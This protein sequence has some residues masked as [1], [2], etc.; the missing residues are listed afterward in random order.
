MMKKARMIWW[1]F[2]C[3]VLLS[4]CRA[5]EPEPVNELEEGE[6]AVLNESAETILPQDS[7]G[8]YP[9]LFATQIPIRAD[10]ATIGSTFANHMPSMQQVGRGGDLWIRYP[11]G[12]LK[13]LTQLAGYGSTGEFQDDDAIAVRD[14][15]VHWD[16]NKAVFSMVIGAP[17][18]QYEWE[19][20]Y[21]QLYEVTG[22]GQ[23][24]TP[25][26]AK[27]PNQPSNYNNVSPVYASDDTIIFTSDRP[28]NG[29][30]H[31]YPQL[32]EYEE[33]PT[34]TGL[35]K[36]NPANGALQLLNHAPSGDFTP[37]VDSFGRVVF[38]QWD[39]LQRDQQADSDA[40]ADSSGDCY[41]GYYYGTFNY[42]NE[43]PDAVPLE[44]RTEIFPEPRS[45]R[46]DLLNG[47]NL[48]GHRF[49][50]FFPWQ[51]NEDGTESEVLNHLGRQEL[52]DY[53][54]NSIS[55]DPN[56]V[57]YYG[58]YP[59]FNPNSIENM[60][61][62]VEDPQQPGRYYGVEAPEFYTHASGQVIRIDAPPT[63]DA[64]HIA[65]THITHPDTA[66]TTDTPDHS[67][68][69]RDPLALSD[70]TLIAAHTFETGPEATSGPALYDFRLRTLTPAGNGYLEADVALTSGISKTVTYWD[71]DASVTY[72]GYLW[73]MY[74]EEVRPRSRPTTPP[75]V[76][77]GPE[78]Q[79]FDQAGVSLG[80]FQAYLE[81]NKLALVVSR[82]VTTR[83]DLDK[84]QP[85]NLNVPAGVQTTGAPGTIYDVVYIQF[86]QADLLRGI[87]W[88]GPG[89][90][91]SPG[92]RVLA[93]IL[94]DPAV[95]NPP[96]PGPQGSAVIAPDGSMAA[97]VPAQRA[98]SW[99]LTDGNGTGMVRERYWLTFQPGEV[100]VCTS[101][102][103][104]SEYDQAGQ[105]APS[106]PP[107]ALLD[108]LLYWQSLGAFDNE[109]YLPAALN[110]G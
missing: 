88:D 55:G 49:N 43:D 3:L 36:L 96:S 91:P 90:D 19:D 29:A 6:S 4:G 84:Q 38:T 65:V 74:P 51:I 81:Q 23:G 34:V 8:S 95:H 109:S 44:D 94:H 86:F 9:I 76:L 14:P 54:S 68:H 66:G 99:Q 2:F 45:C 78:Q 25:V 18:Q 97:F 48:V 53:I 40:H 63:T 42:S 21:W 10:F 89:D 33:T 47:T 70:G 5:S 31:L 41:G 27:V 60:F 102:H 26:I 104:L 61:Q 59:R 87:G 37:I 16:G 106:N 73:E 15:A 7:G 58:Q 101:C 98:L 67:G 83:D 39:H 75:F 30:A 24:D 72:S 62:I 103:G 17:E 11:N 12:V 92:R 22:L 20:Y 57:E 64:D 46:D 107:Q 105:S 52:H 100:R 77:P 85:F 108:L 69:Y 13:N 35:W 80:V 79:M 82:D 71:P 56:I 32:D 28:H 1:L 93:Q 110:A 50:H